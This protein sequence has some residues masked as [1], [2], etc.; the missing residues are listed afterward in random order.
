M[1]N[2]DIC[3]FCLNQARSSC[4]PCTDEGKYRYLEFDTYRTNLVDLHTIP[5]NEIVDMPAP[6]RLA[7]MWLMTQS[8]IQAR[9]PRS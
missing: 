6:D 8:V 2:P 7:L 1:K 5:M 9:R 4:L 3:R